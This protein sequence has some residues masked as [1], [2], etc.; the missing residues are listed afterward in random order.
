[1]VTSSRRLVG[2]NQ[3]WVTRERN[4]DHDALAHAARKLMRVLFEAAD[5][6][7]DA[8]K[9]QEFD[10]T[11]MGGGPVG[12]AVLF[13]RLGDLSADRQNRVQRGHGLLKD[14]ANIAAA[15]LADLLLRQAQ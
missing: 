4:R 8:D 1:M 5:R 12:P 3:L 15:H 7:G 9:P 11:R 10:R 13:E 2:D 14:H 6:I